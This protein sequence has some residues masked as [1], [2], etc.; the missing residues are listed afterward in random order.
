MSQQNHKSSS[1]PIWK[2]GIGILGALILGAVLL[3]GGLS[4]AVD[5]QAFVEQVG[6]EGLDFALSAGT[7]ALV[8]IGLEIGLGAALLLGVRRLWILLPAVA[9]VGLFMFLTGRGYWN[10]AHGIVDEAASC[11]CFGNLLDRTPAEAFWQDLLLMVP[12][13]LLCFFGRVPSGFPRAR[14]GL[15]VAMTLVGIVFSWKAPD[16]PLD[17]IATRLKPGKTAESICSGGDDN[18]L[19]ITGL[20]PDLEAGT[21]LVILADLA[22]PAFGV[23]V[24]DLNQYSLSGREPKLWVL[25]SSSPEEHRLFFWQ[26][27]PTFQITEAPLTLIRPLYR[28]LP[29]SFLVSDGKVVQTFS[30]LP[31]LD[32]LTGETGRQIESGPKAGES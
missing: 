11:G 6:A 7:V 24:A 15:A 19:C 14:L 3:V 32:S 26:R 10:F 5:P 25:S 1:M 23:A 31:P 27:A 21:H 4:K 22:S 16:L 2:R 12:A 18:R 9:L 17:D 30:G 8:A 28:T 20:I 13:L 29:R